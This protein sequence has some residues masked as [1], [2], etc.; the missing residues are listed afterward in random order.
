MNS[1]TDLTPSEARRLARVLDA[2]RTEPAP[3]HLALSIMAAARPRTPSFRMTWPRLATLAAAACLG[4]IVGW[5]DTSE[6]YATR[7]DANA[8][9]L[10]TGDPIEGDVL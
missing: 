9:A 2:W 3:R 1:E 10:F 7:Y 8:D 6:G 4:L 5:A